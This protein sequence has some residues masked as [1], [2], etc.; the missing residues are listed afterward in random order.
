MYVFNLQGW[1]LLSV[2]ATKVAGKAMEYTNIASEK[3]AEYSH[4]ISD[5]VSPVLLYVY[6]LQE[7]VNV[8]ICFSCAS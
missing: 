6:L 1:S 8:I 3:A 2:G 7:N 5:K 4:T